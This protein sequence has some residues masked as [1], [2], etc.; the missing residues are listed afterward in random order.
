MNTS[1]AD[2]A[3]LNEFAVKFARKLKGGETVAL[4]GNLGAGKTTFT[5]MLL[6]AA[7]LKNKVTSPTFVLMIPYKKGK[8]T[9]YHIDLYR[10]KSFKDIKTLGVEQLWAQ[11]NNIFIIEW[12]E[13]IK[14]YLPKNTTFLKF[15]IKP[16]NKREV[17][18][19]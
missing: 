9:F 6:K 13:K 3:E 18:I 17:Q 14:R 1:I 11:K 7:G 4:I 12:A 19:T 15:K 10:T 2:L 5:K 16:N 8:K